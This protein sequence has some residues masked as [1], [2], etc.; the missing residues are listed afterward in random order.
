MKALCV[1]V[2]SKDFSIIKKSFLFYLII[3]LYST[4]SY[5]QNSAI[6]THKNNVLKFEIRYNARTEPG[7]KD[8]SNSNLNYCLSQLKRKVSGRATYLYD[9]DYIMKKE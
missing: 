1:S 5:S 7:I 6:L 9:S 4:V 8:F 2:I 3:G